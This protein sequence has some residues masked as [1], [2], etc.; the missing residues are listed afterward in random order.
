[1][2]AWNKDCV[3]SCLDTQVPPALPTSAPL[4]TRLL[5]HNGLGWCWLRQVTRGPSICAKH[6]GNDV[7]RYDYCGFEMDM[8]WT[9]ISGSLVIC[10]Q[11]E[12]ETNHKPIATPPFRQRQGRGITMAMNKCTTQVAVTVASDFLDPR[13][14]D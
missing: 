14:I 11:A 1:M 6:Y 13:P 5:R 12:E 3:L 10:A 2:S 4:Q 8:C 9:L 7:S